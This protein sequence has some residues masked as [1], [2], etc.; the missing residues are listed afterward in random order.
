MGTHKKLTPKAQELFDLVKAG[1]II[2]YRPRYGCD[3]RIYCNNKLFR[4]DAFWQLR[5]RLIGTPVRRPKG[6]AIG[7]D[8]SLK[9]EA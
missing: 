9:G 1:H 5:H 8:Y 7:F 4:F 6:P 2:S 3:P